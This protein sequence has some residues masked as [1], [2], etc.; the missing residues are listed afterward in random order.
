MDPKKTTEDTPAGHTQTP[1]MDILWSSYFSNDV[2]LL[3]VEIKTKEMESDLTTAQ[4]QLEQAREHN[5]TMRKALEEI[6]DYSKDTQP[7][8]NSILHCA[9]R[10][11]T[12]SAPKEKP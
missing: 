9:H 8:M 1:W 3:Y 6:L 2:G 7:R 5:E 10:A 4:H 12:A 11:L